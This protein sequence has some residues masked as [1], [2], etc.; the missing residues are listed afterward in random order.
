VAMDTVR[1]FGSDLHTVL[2]AAVV[3]RDAQSAAAAT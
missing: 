3:R 1:E 2:L